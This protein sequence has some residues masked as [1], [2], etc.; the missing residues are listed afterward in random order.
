[1]TNGNGVC[2]DS[3]RISKTNSGYGQSLRESRQPVSD[4]KPGS[5]AA[6]LTLRC[7][8]H[9]RGKCL[10][11]LSGSVQ[12]KKA[13]SGI[14]LIGIHPYSMFNFGRSMFDVQLAYACPLFLYY[15]FVMSLY[16]RLSV[17]KFSGRPAARTLTLLSPALK[18]R[19]QEREGFRARAVSHSSTGVSTDTSSQPVIMALMCARIR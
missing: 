1:M 16:F 9:I 14:A 18:H 8:L 7:G 4:G 11:E 15:G 13:A 6:R 3:G 12:S 10:S 2:V 5:Q 19:N 17:P